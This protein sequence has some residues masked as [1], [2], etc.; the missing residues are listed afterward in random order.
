V[1][2]NTTNYLE[3]MRLPMTFN[4]IDY[5][6]LGHIA[7]DVKTDEIA[8]GGS[9]TYAALTAKALGLKVGIATV[10]TEET[11]QKQELS[12]IS[13]AFQ[14]TDET[15][16]FENIDSS[17]GRIQYIH[18]LAPKIETKL[19]PDIWRST[20]I[21][22]IAPVAQEIDPNII[23]SFPNAFIG[24]TPQGWLR[25]WDNLGK[26]YLAEWPEA[27]YVLEK[28]SAAVLS[29][30][31]ME[32]KEDRIEE[33]I[34]S[35][36]TLA[37]TEGADGVRLYWNGDLRRFRPPDVEE[38]DSVGA[39]DIFAAAFFIRLYNS[40]NPWEAARFAT[41]LAAISVTRIGLE[42]I[43]TED[44]IQGSIIEILENNKI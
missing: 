13:I 4:P 40:H 5:L 17:A 12:G 3:N 20:P 38:I 15:T 34:A 30:E 33:L 29:N 22:H 7:Q 11:A 6:I 2:L 42:S 9:A 26:V 41:R 14:P 24:L 32:F 10:C 44:E 43:P 37:V 18:K 28:S 27:S 23:L 21:V 1:G 36:R 25:G 16:T 39:G 8:L 35:I 31:D 19:I